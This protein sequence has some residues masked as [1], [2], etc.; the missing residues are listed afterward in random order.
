MTYRTPLVVL[1]SC[2]ALALTGC[3]SQSRHNSSADSVSMSGPANVKCKLAFS[4]TGWSAVVKHASGTGVVSCDNGARQA[5]TISAKG[6]GITLGKYHIDNGHGT[7]TDVHGIRETY[8]NYIQGEAQ[9]GATK[10]ANAQV[11]SKGTVS[12]ALAG[13]GQGVGLGVSVGVFTIEPTP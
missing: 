9:A 1:A 6:G 3:A 5:V 8:G 2:L 10:S 7:F 13:S 12:L 11:M 4:L